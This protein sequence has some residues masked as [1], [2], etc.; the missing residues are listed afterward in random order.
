MPNVFHLYKS[1]NILIHKSSDTVFVKGC[2]FNVILDLI[3]FVK[4][5]LT[6]FI[7]VPGAGL[8]GGVVPGGG[9]VFPGGTGQVV[10][11][12]GLGGKSLKVWGFLKELLLCRL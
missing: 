1:I 5:V 9:G 3:W 10:P 11:G 2:A 6:H 12:G 4:A 8:G 7:G